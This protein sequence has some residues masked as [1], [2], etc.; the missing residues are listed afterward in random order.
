MNFHFITETLRAVLTSKGST[1]IEGHT[2][3]MWTDAMRVVRE[4]VN[5]S[6]V[7]CQEADPYKF[8]IKAASDL[9]AWAKAQDLASIAVLPT[10]SPKASSTTSSEAPAAKPARVRK[11]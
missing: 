3:A 10:A 8:Q 11:P 7:G 5:A 1:D 2:R 9:L 4:S 6:L